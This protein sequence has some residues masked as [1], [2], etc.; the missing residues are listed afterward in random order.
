MSFVD[1][2][3]SEAQEHTGLETQ[4]KIIA[5]SESF[6][7]QKTESGIS[8]SQSSV[9]EIFKLGTDLQHTATTTVKENE[10]GASM[11]TSFEAELSEKDCF[12]LLFT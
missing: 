1:V 2:H 8:G 9:V 11:Y 5:G 3:A 6:D 10:S 7:I 12:L 4:H